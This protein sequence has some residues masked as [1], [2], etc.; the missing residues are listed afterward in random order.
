MGRSL[1][2]LIALLADLGA[3]GVAFRS[4]REHI[5]T[6]SAGGRFVFHM[7]GAL[8]EF[9]RELISERTKAGLCAARARGATL[10]RPRKLGSAALQTLRTI[11]AAD[12]NAIE[13]FAERY[14][15]APITVRRALNR[16]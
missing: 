6:E 2:H 8:A 4:L 13:R 5:D 14:G 1:Q 15:V 10:G 9:E 3:Q 12:R 7:M 16:V 11:D